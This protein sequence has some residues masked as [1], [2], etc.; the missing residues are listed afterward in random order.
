MSALLIT[1]ARVVTPVPASD[2]TSRRGHASGHLHVHDGTDVLCEQGLITAV[3]P[4]ITP[5]AG[6]VVLEA[7]GRVLL[8]GLIDCHTHA[9]W[10]GDRLDEWSM[11]LAGRTYLD[12]LAAGGGIMSTVRAVRAA[13]EHDLARTLLDRLKLALAC[14]TTTIE[15]KSGY[16]LDTQSELKMLRAIRRAGEAWPGTVVPTACIG[17]ALD[18]DLCPPGDTA[19]AETF[20]QGTITHTLPAVHAA[21][22]GIAIDAYCE[23][24]AWTLDQCARLFDAA[25]ALGHPCRVHTDQFNAL[26]MLDAAIARRFVSVDH[27]EASTREALARLA[28]S[29]TTGV[30]LPCSGFHT[31]GRSANARAVLDAGGRVALATNCNPGSAPCISMPFAA[32]LAVRFCGLTPHEAISASTLAPAHVL[33]LTDRGLIKPGKRADLVLLR[34]TDE[35]ELAHS[36]GDSPVAVTIAA[37]R[38]VHTEAGTPSAPPLTR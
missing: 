10:A 31:D 25:A 28:A 34:H 22:P 37:G 26:G 32:A 35:R 15:V 27:L 3:A 12:I 14:G 18:A 30:I 5:P 13:S 29:D 24:S 16:G 4:R 33:G 23:H 20:V 19:A 8:P 21:F 36:F 11:R 6:A 2:G 17:H 7:A 9:C 1:N 38:V